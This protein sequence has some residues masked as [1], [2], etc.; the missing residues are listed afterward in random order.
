M[1]TFFS[2]P[3]PFLGHIGVIQRNALLSWKHTHPEAEVFLFGDEEGTRE[4]CTELGIT[5]CPQVERNPHGTKYLRSIFNQAQQVARHDLLCYLN[6]DI[7][8]T[9]DFLL[10]AQSA[11]SAPGPFLLAG[12]RWDVDVKTPLDFSS[13][14]WAADI[15]Q[16]AKQTN[17]QRPA[18]W[19]DYFLFRRGLFGAA[20]PPFVIGRPGWDNWLLWHALSSGARLIDASPV[21]TAVHQNHDYGYHPDGEKGV[22]QGD[23]AQANYALLE[24]YRKFATL[25]DAALVLESDGFHP[26]RRRHVVRVIR[27]FARARDKMWF[28]LLNLTRPVRHRLGIKQ[29]VNS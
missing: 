20:I 3:K 11:A 9:E 14:R 28:G 23:E 4:T 5:H 16:L 17:R 13:D 15:V 19:I 27:S 29:K 25:D 2:T 1:L 8:L 26:N 7:I 12:R 24:D 10:A 18:Q 22:W 6:C 21:V